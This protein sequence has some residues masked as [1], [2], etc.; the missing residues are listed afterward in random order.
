MEKALMERAIAVSRTRQSNRSS[1]VTGP[2]D[3]DRASL[4]IRA[5]GSRGHRTRTSVYLG[6]TEVAHGFVDMPRNRGQH[7]VKG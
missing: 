7:D 2:T 6:N 4:G 3:A 5:V 1:V